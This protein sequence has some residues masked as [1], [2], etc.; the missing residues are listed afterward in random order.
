M[1]IEDDLREE[2][3]ALRRILQRELGDKYGPAM[4]EVEEEVEVKRSSKSAAL[5][6]LVSESKPKSGVAKDFLIR[7]GE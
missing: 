6:K 2:V 3:F 7:L 1:N 4:K 5:M